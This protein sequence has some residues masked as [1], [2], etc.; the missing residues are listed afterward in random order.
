VNDI[1]LFAQ[2]VD[3]AQANCWATSRRCS[4]TSASWIRPG[5][6]RRQNHGR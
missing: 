6:S 4:V 3:P 1:G 5:P 2:E